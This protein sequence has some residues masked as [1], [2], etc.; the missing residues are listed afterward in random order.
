M[1]K[2]ILRW[3]LTA[4]PLVFGVSAL[5][6]VLASLIPGDAARA[7]LGINA[8][9]Q[10]YQQLR[11]QLGLDKPLW[12]QYTEWL[13]NALHGDLG[14]S[15]QS[16][17]SVSHEILGRVTVTL[18]LVGG[19][20]LVAVVV[21]V[22]LGVAS[23][24]RGGVL[25]KVVDVFALLGL[26]VPSYWLGLVLVTLFAV[27]LQIFPATGYIEFGQSPVRWFESLVMPVLTLGFGSCAPIAKQ[28]RDGMLTELQR[29]YVVTLR[30]RGVRERRIVLLHAMRNA[31]TPVLSVAGLVLVG[32]FGG[33]VLAE[34]VF[35][36]PG[37]GSLAVNA[38]STHDIPVIQGVA[39]MFTVL[40]V[41][42]NLLIELGYAALNPKVRT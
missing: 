1:R 7:I 23:A 25:G 26:A 27:K 22:G 36:L 15:I 14:D 39:I 24:L 17:G 38:A 29:D 8:N 6:F 2:L 11:Q 10:Q 33:A 28:T 3:L 4:V 5:T 20:I 21:G 30:A 37:L 42:V 12:K 13:T 40:V 32:L 18:W 19:A 35:V 34:T 31:A 9:P 16:S 41:L